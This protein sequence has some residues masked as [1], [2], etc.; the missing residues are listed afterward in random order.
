MNC[1]RNLRGAV[2][3]F[4]ALKWGGVELTW[5]MILRLK[6]LY[7]DRLFQSAL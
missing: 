5:E 7:L 6:T 2:S 1:M 3:D 4:R